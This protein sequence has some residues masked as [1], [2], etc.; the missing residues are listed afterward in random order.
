[1]TSPWRTRASNLGIVSLRREPFVPDSMFT[2]MKTVLFAHMRGA[3]GVII[4]IVLYIRD[5]C[6]GRT[7]PFGEYERLFT[8]SIWRRGG[9]VPAGAV[10]QNQ[11]NNT[12]PERPPFSCETRN[13]AHRYD[14]QQGGNV[15]GLCGG[16][17]LGDQGEPTPVG[18]QS[19]DGETQEVAGVAVQRAYVQAAA[20][21][22]AA[23]RRPLRDAAGAPAW[24]KPHQGGREEVAE[25]TVAQAEVPVRLRGRRQGLQPRDL[26]P[27]PS[28]V[29]DG[30]ITLNF[31]V[32]FNVKN[33]HCTLTRLGKPGVMQLNRSGQHSFCSR[34]RIV[35]VLHLVPHSYV[36]FYCP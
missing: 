28:P 14:A 11:N 21:V 9:P 12:D 7:C 29:D 20:A 2:F 1:M 24:R 19:G 8:R 34:T 27:T 33:F 32:S 15:P 18:L 4:S 13:R 25:G 6:A 35:C 17:G 23:T 30:F 3:E 36:S 5:S 16:A 22:A 26:N 10:P 31:S